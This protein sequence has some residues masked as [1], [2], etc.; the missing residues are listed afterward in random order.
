MQAD[1]RSPYADLIMFDLQ[2]AG[3][4]EDNLSM[5]VWSP[6]LSPTAKKPVSVVLHGG[7]FYAGSLN[8]SGMEGEAMARFA[9]SVVVAVNHRL[10]ALGYLHLAEFGGS[11]F[12]TSG[13]VGMQD[14]V[15]A[16][17]WI[18]TN[19]ANFGGDPSRVLVFGQSGGGAKTSTLMAMPSAKGLFHRAGVMS[20]SALRMMPEEIAARNAKTFLDALGIGKGDV[21]KLQDIPFTRLI[22]TQALLEASAGAK[23]EAPGSFAPVVDGTVLPRHPFSPD[24]P[25]IS[26]DVPMIV[27]TALD[28]RSYRLMDFGMTEDGLL[29]FAR[30][31]AGDQAPEAVKLYRDED[32]SAKPFILAA[33]MD[34]DLWFRKSAFTMA[35]L[36]A[37]QGAAPVWTYLWTWPSPAYDGRFGAVH[38][39]DVGPSL[40]SP[41]GGLT[42]SGAPARQMAKRLASAWAAFAAKGDPNN[43]TLPDWAAYDRKTR[44][45]LILADDT[46]VEADPRAEIR[47]FWKDKGGAGRLGE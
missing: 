43:P 11:D 24:A 31:R 27:S 16:L 3:P 33:R 2:P 38:G 8:S 14:I 26:A 32:R 46:R 35:E 6:D 36:K 22:E 19:I 15:A 18:N 34:S 28:E 7:G 37:A 45:T 25:A 30:E 47:E 29:A 12:S 10:G 41:R 5:N 44:S 1:R 13:N 42:G 4:G 21:R 23:G 17:R 40:Y 9:D 20:G 39:I